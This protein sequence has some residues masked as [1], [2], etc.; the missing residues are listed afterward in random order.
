MKKLRLLPLLALSAA[1]LSACGGNNN[2]DESSAKSESGQPQESG[3]SQESNANNASSS[4]EVVDGEAVK[5][6]LICLHDTSSTYDKNFIDALDQAAKELGKKIIYEK[7]C[8]LTN[9]NEDEACYEAAK[10][11]VDKDCKVIFADSFGHQAFM[12]RAAQEYEDVH[13]CH[14]T[15]TNA[16]TAGLKNYH[17]AFAS[18]YQGR[19]LAGYAAGLKLVDTKKAELDA[20]NAL[21]VGYVGAYTYA[22]VMSGYTSWFLGVRNA[23][24][25]YNYDDQKVTMDVRFTG[26]WYDPNG[27]ASAADA[28]IKDGCVLISQHADSMGAPSTCEQAGIPNV[29]YN[30]ETKSDCPN[31]YLAYSRINWAPYYK[32]VVNAV[33][34]GKDID[35]EV[36]HN[37][38]GTIDTGSVEYNVNWDNLSKDAAKLEEYKAKFAAV[39]K[40][41]KE[42]ASAYVFDCSKFTVKGQHLTTYMA[43]TDG[44]ADF[45]PD[46]EAIKT[47]GGVTFFNE[48]AVASAPYFNVEIDGI[49]L[50]NR[51]Y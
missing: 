21:K 5:V 31:T 47:E 15:G 42:K 18:I 27:E 45:K 36:A 39:E 17:N 10:D 35:S 8:L 13:F 26:S 23:L 43:D 9:I 4:E 48:S 51:Q 46:T 40:N 32:A 44:D 1:C 33:F 29:T 12:L 20:G 22:E 16:K 19:F 38:T 14:A 7:N 30:V 6:G 25:D 28:L 49:N 37:W 24:R 34:A 41:V 11:L 3:S 2:K 50:Q